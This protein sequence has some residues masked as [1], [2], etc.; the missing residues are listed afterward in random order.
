MRQIAH[1]LLKVMIP[2]YKCNIE[3]NDG[4]IFAG[5][6]AFEGDEDPE[7][8][9]YNLPKN[10]PIVNGEKI[11]RNSPCPCGSGLKYKKCCIK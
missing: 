6:M 4:T 7:I 1:E 11:S 9:L 2:D 3:L 5:V 8:P 10:R